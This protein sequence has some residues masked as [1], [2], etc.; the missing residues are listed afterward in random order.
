M[1][2]WYLAEAKAIDAAMMERAESYQLTLT[3]PP[4]ALGQLEQLAIQFSGYQSRLK[5][6]LETIEI[7]VMAADHGVAG[8]NVSAFPQAVTGEMVKNFASGGAAISVLARQLNARLTVI[9]LGTV[10]PLPEIEGVLDRR[11]AAGT[12]NFCKVPAMTVEQLQ[13]ALA[14][15]REA[16]EAAAR[17]GAQLFIGGEMGIANTTSAACLAARLLGKYAEQMTGPGTGLDAAGVNHKMAVVERALV[18]HPEVEV[19][20][21]LQNLGG[22]EIAGLVGAYI[23]C[24]Q[25]G[26]PVLLDGYITTAA[27]L[28]AE[29]INP[30]IQ[31]WLLASHQSA[32]PAHIDMLQGLKLQPLLDLGMRLGEGSGAAV[33][34][35]IVQAACR[36]QSEMASFAN[37]GVSGKLDA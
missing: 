33:A 30:S 9:N 2:E 15:G 5:P 34:A 10:E 26:I 28:I 36:L 3:K 20:Q 7:V 21:V 12:A 29:Q 22:F 37:A 23:G 13:Q 8:E 17:R 27:A 24:A 11:I 18:R 6:V 25:L 32:E 14:I 4:G 16:A 31:P 35:T 19:M 1:S